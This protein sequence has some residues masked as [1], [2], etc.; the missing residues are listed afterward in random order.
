MRNT[1]VRNA[2]RGQCDIVILQPEA[3]EILGLT[4]LAKALSSPIHSYTKQKEADPDRKATEKQRN[5]TES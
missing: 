3:A 5:G 4:A 1:S 2:P